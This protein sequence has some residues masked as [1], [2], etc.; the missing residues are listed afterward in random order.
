M[1]K[2]TVNKIKR[3]LLLIRMYRRTPNDD[4]KD[5]LGH[6]MKNLYKLLGIII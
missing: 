1:A 2:G 6:L 5:I 3:A 4:I